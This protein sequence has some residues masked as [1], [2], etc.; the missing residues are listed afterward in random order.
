MIGESQQTHIVTKNINWGK[1]H[2]HPFYII[3]HKLILRGKN[4][5]VYSEKQ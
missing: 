4:I 5:N 1:C 3:F 2:K